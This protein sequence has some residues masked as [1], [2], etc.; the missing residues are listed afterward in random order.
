MPVSHQ[1]PLST[2]LGAAGKTPPCHTPLL[3]LCWSGNLILL[4]RDNS[5]GQLSYQT[6]FGQHQCFLGSVP[7]KAIALHVRQQSKDQKT[8]IIKAHG[9]ICSV[10][11]MMHHII[12]SCIG[13]NNTT[14]SD[15][16]IWTQEMS[17]PQGCKESG[18]SLIS[19]SCLRGDRKEQWLMGSRSCYSYFQSLATW[20]TNMTPDY[21]QI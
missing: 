18:F 5:L 2:V 8:T 6:F 10:K 1:K 20:M 3:G 13:W 11:T 9:Q 14:P 7:Y 12:S 21:T 17:S 4:M 16:E 19:C 15:Q